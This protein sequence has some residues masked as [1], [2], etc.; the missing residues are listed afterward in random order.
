MFRCNPLILV[1]PLV[2]AVCAGCGSSSSSSSTT[3]PGSSSS[4]S[5]VAPTACTGTESLVIVEATDDGSN[6]GHGPA[7]VL[8]GSLNSDSRWSS[9]G[10]D[11]ALVLDLGT[12]A[13]IAEVKTAWLSADERT[14]FYTIEAS[15]DNNNWVTLVASGQS[16]GT[17]GFYADTFDRLDAQ[18]VRIIGQGNSVNLWNSLLEVEVHGCGGLDEQPTIPN[19][20][21]ALSELDPNQPPSENFD[22][23]RWYISIPTDEDGNGRADNIKEDDLNDGYEQPDY[24][25]TGADGG[26]VFRVGPTGFKTSTNTSYTRVE[27][28]EMLRAGNT[29]I[30]TQGVNANNWVFG[31]APAEDLAAAGGVDGN[32]RATLAVNRVSTTGEAYQ[33]GRVIIG[34]IHANDDEPVRLYYRKLPSNDKGSIYLAHEIQGGD[35]TWYDMIGGR[36]NIEFNPED[37]IA[38]DEVFSYEINVEGNELTVFIYREGKPTVKQVVD[39]SS[40]GYDQGGQ[41]MYF[42]AGAYNQN[43]TADEEDYTQATFYALEHSHD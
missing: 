41:Y 5:S 3:I 18:Y 25:Y 38:L 15:T 37:G 40:S 24:F 21:P 30:D 20:P 9:E 12:L 34:Q 13:N 42:K 7:N 32:M 2:A 23:S 22:L 27:L 35:D 11:K 17:E 26:M 6:D 16:Q 14:A 43:N 10:D 31:S 29:S 1:L 36:S 28:R 39:M 19:G 4:S 33:I 8:D